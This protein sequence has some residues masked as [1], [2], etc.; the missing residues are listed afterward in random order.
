MK[1]FV[2]TVRA[3]FAT[4]LSR[5]IRELFLSVSLANFAVSM[6][7]LFEPIYLYNLGFSIATILY[8]YGGVYVLYLIAIPIGAKFAR[9]F[10]YEKAI[11]LGSPFWAV[12]YC[13]LFLIPQN[14][15]FVYIAIVAFALQKTFYWPGYHA[16]F[17]RFGRSKERGREMS[18]LIALSAVVYIAGPILGGVIV[19]VWGFGTLFITAT[20]IILAS[21]LPLLATPEKFKPVPFSYTDAFRR[22]WAKENRRNFFGFLGFGE[23]LIVM[24]IWPI[25]IYVVLAN[26]V[27]IGLLAALATLATTAAS[28][29][30]G[31]LVDGNAHD[32]QSVLRIGA[33]FSSA[34]WFLRMLVTGSLG[35]FLVDSL[36]RISKNVI[37]IPMMAMTYQQAS[38]SSVMK[39]MI[40]FEMSLI[41]GKIIAIA[42]A[43]FAIWV[44]PQSF[45][46][47]FLIA[48]AMTPLYGLIRFS[49]VK[50]SV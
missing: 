42:I 16:D 10:G 38:E 35:V 3:F 37:V 4:K 32:R 49:P 46:P 29:F 47:L 27:T 40:F 36:S 15:T 45:A 2:K 31:K 14:P 41:V 12:Y 20:L 21:N 44:I 11:L 28:L 1:I 9:R 43:L 25:F 19:S 30:V 50:L 34:T 48:A 18:N 6:V 39:T 33:V 23:E 17:A 7:A 22:L 8:F 26:Y 24:V 5:Q 13:A